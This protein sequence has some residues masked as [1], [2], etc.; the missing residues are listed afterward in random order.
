MKRA[1]ERKKRK[2]EEVDRRRVLEFQT[3]S[4][5]NKNKDDGER[6]AADSNVEE[7]KA[8]VNNI[9]ASI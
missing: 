3:P 9:I 4:P 1:K 6:T 8:D 5:T 2:K 7:K